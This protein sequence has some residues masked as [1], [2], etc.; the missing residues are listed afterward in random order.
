MTVISHI[1]AH[2]TTIIVSF[3]WMM[4][5]QN[6]RHHKANRH[7]EKRGIPFKKHNLIIDKV[8][9]PPLI[10][11]EFTLFKMKTKRRQY[12]YGGIFQ[13]FFFMP[14]AY[15]YSLQKIQKTF[16]RFE[17]KM[18]ILRRKIL[19]LEKRTDFPTIFPSV[20]GHD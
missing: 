16:R 19:I 8:G 7:E 11:E 10:R 2:K 6:A 15:W 3:W 5:G 1:M 14:I 17:E 12:V 9:N 13:D 18:L 4:R 20:H